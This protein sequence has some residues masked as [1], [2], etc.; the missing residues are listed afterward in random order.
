MAFSFLR[1]FLLGITL[2]CLS[3]WFGRAIIQSMLPLYQWTITQFDS[4]IEIISLA[5]V[6]QH[7]QQFLQLNTILTQPFFI[8]M[9][10]FVPQIAIPS[11]SRIPLD[12]V[13][14]PLVIFLT[15]AI[16]WPASAYRDSLFR[17]AIGAPLILILMLLDAPLQ[18]NYMLWDSVEGLVQTMGKVEG[19]LRPWSDFLNGG[20]LIM[21]SLTISIMSIGLSKL[22]TE[23]NIKVN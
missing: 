15:L 5:I 9:H 18:F 19:Y 3:H 14:Q 13:L 23:K 8:G 21:L 20:G 11:S 22:L 4:Q 2:A 6:Q 16:G 12:F 10:Y 17:L 7:G 1:V